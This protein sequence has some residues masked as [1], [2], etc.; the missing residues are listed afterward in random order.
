[1]NTRELSPRGRLPAAS[2]LRGKGQALVEFALIFPVFLLLTVG[3]VDLARVFSAD[4]AL[5]S[6]VRGAAMWAADGTQN[7][8][9]CAIPPADAIRCPSGSA[10]HQYA[11]PDNIAYQIK[12]A[13]TGLDASK[14]TMQTPVCDPD[15]CA[16]GGNVK[17]IASYPM[18]LL[19]PVLSNILGGTVTMTASTTA[20]VISQ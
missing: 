6:G 4:I 1:M 18:P 17:I 2:D 15:P 20:R 5:N 9:W 11:D 14:I 12:V 16:S 10:G 7:T 13:A 8:K 3:V 19:T